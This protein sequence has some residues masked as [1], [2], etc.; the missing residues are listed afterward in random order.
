MFYLNDHDRKLLKVTVQQEQ[1]LKSLVIDE[2]GPGTILRDFEMLLNL[3]KETPLE[4]TPTHQL[5]SNAITLINSKLVNPI[6]HGLKPVSQKSFPQVHGLFLLV[7]A[8]GLTEVIPTK[9][10]RLLE[11]ADDLYTQWQTFNS[12]DRYGNLLESWYLRTQS[13]EYQGLFDI[14]ETFVRCVQLWFET[15][16]KGRIAKERNGL[17]S[18]LGSYLGTENLGLMDLFGLVQIERSRVVDKRGWQITQI[19]NMPLADAMFPALA[20][21][22]FLKST[23]GT[24][25]SRLVSDYSSLF[26]V[27]KPVMQA[28]WPRWQRELPLA[29]AE[30]REGCYTFKLA[31]KERR[32]DL[33]L[34]EMWRQV[35][36]DASATLD[37]LAFALLDSIDFDADHL[38]QFAYQTRYG[39]IQQVKPPQ[40]KEHDL[41][42]SQVLVGNLPLKIGQTMIFTFDFGAN[43]QFAVTL[44]KIKPGS[45]IHTPEIIGSHG[46]APEQYPDGEDFAFFFDDNFEEIDNDDEEDAN[47][48]DDFIDIDL[49]NV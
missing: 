12:Y 47:D 8:S 2:N 45:V 20:D 7:Q 26:G 29:A 28:Y 10:G 3:I 9:K 39:T 41:D 30:F 31:L 13:R 33:S 40:M 18:E 35:A 23:L 37:D 19:N 1:F 44:E 25:M 24:L 5:S 15:R 17:L 32:S 4:L 16:A 46:K 34:N 42:T 48:G 49:S 36:I 43:W 27:L 38:Y 21:G 14:N 22:Y 6:E 11:I